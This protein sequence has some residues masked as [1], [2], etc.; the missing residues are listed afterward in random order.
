MTRAQSNFTRNLIITS[1]REAQSR[2]ESNRD[3]HC[4]VAK[5]KPCA[6][7]DVNENPPFEGHN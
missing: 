7:Y 5:I 3:E 2:V 6:M 4:G 1:M